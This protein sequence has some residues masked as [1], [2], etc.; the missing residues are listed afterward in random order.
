MANADLEIWVG[1][2]STISLRNINAI[3]SVAVAGANHVDM[4]VAMSVPI[5]ILFMVTDCDFLRTEL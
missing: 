1:R 5:N 2:E 4:R 3:R